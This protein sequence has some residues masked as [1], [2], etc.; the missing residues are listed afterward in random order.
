VILPILEF[1]TTNCYTIYY[2]ISQQFRQ[3]STL[4]TFTF[5]REDRE[6]AHN[7]WCGPLS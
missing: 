4:L 3:V 1:G 7:N 5:Q 2:N 6:S